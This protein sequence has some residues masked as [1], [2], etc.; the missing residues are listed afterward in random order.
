VIR[1]RDLFTKRFRKVPTIEP[2]ELQLQQA[3]VARLRLQCK[4]GIIWY[5]VPNGEAGDLAKAAYARLSSIKTDRDLI[6]KKIAAE[7]AR[8]GAKRKSMGVRAGVAD[9]EFVFPVPRPN[10]YLELKARGRDLSPEQQIFRADVRAAGHYY[11][12][13]DTIDEAVRVL[14]QYRI[15]P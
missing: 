7:Q 5:H 10:L 14:R 8:A 2:S 11:E 1:Q 3:V 6:Q 4:S 15:I 9:L 12:M 13:A